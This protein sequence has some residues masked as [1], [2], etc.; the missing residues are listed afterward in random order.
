MRRIIFVSFIL[1]LF[2]GVADADNFKIIDKNGNFYLAYSPVYCNRELQGYTDKYGR[3]TIN[4]PTDEY[5]CKIVYRDQSRIIYLD[6]D[7]S[8]D[9]K[10][11]YSK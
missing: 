10:V 9:Q 11:I 6:I 4:L 1:F 3:I 5:R 7:G 2:V 8:R